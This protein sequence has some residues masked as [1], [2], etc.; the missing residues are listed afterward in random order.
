MKLP[1]GC[2]TPCPDRV[3][4]WI[5]SAVLPPYSA[6][7]AP[8]ITSIDWIEFEGIWLENVLLVWSV[9]ACP[10]TEN[11]FDAWSPNP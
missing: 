8:E 11:E 1:V 2:V 3:V 9:I 4:T 10:S 6:G 7:G 5:T